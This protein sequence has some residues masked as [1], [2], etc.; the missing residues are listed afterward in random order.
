MEIT[1]EEDELEPTMRGNYENQLAFSMTGFAFEMI[2]IQKDKVRAFP[3]SQ[4]SS[5][6]KRG[7]SKFAEGSSVIGQRRPLGMMIGSTKFRK[8]FDQSDS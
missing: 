7:A 1:P 2:E 6:L 4:A 8:F 3:D 5:P